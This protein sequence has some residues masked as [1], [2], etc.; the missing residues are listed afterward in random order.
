MTSVN[1][2]YKEEQYRLANHPMPKRGALCTA[3]K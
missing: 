1:E 2:Q 3:R